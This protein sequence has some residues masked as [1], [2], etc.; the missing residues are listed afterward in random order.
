MDY[1]GLL[2]EANTPTEFLGMTFYG[3]AQASSYPFALNR[4]KEVK[5]VVIRTYP[6]SLMARCDP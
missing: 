6:D 3:G 1:E 2:P 5:S 4:A